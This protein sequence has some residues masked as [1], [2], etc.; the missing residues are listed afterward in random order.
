VNWNKYNESLVKRGEILLD[1][2]VIDNWSIELE[3][4]NEGKQGRKFV[5]PDSFIKLLGYMR[6]YFHLPYR[7]TEGVVRQHA[8]DTLPSIPDYSRICRRINILDIKINY[9][10]EDKTS[11][12]DDNFVIAV[13]STGI[14]VTN[15]GE[16][17]RHKWNVKRGY[18]KIHVAVDIK[19]KRILSLIVTSEQVHDG[20]V[21]PKLVDNITIKQNKEIDMTIADGAYDNNNNFQILSFRGIKPAIKVRKNSKCRKTNHYL[22]NKSVK[23]QKN[24]LQQWKDSVSYGQRWIAET[25]FSCIK[26]MFGEYV[27]AIRFENMIKEMVLKASL[28][29]LFQS[30]TVR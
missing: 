24:N 17:V 21:L 8:S 23:I 27:T 26:R 20:K 11:L 3:K 19:R 18:L 12:H 5:Y 28:Y 9:D 10:D 22:R 13:D 7:Q 1:F 14:K 29:N 4:M 30:I 6:A 2:D 25:V 15:R 16:W